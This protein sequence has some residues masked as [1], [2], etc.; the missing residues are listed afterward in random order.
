MNPSML[1]DIFSCQYADSIVSCP[2]V[3]YQFKIDLPEFQVAKNSE[4][5]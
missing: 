5:N 4:V 2:L 1:F 3:F